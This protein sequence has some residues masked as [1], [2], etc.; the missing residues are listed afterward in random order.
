[1]SISAEDTPKIPSDNLFPVVGVGASAGGLEAFKQ[2]LQAIPHNS[3]LAYILVQ[4]LDPSH[5]SIL[6]EILQRVSKIPVHEIADNMKV[7]ADHIYIIPSNKILV[8]TDGVLKLDERLPKPHKNMPI[9][10]FFSSLAEVHREHA[11]GV[12]L[13]GTGTDGTMGLKAIKDQGGLTFAQSPE[14]AAYDGMPLSA[15]SSN[16]VD[17]ILPPADIPAKLLEL[18]QTINYSLLN[19]LEAEAK[20]KENT[21]KQILALLQLRTKVDFT[22]YKQTT[23]RRRILRR[24]VIHKLENLADYLKLARDNKKEQ[25]NL[26]QDLLIPVT[27]FFRDIQTFESVFHTILP[28]IVKDKSLVVPIRIWVAGC[29]TGQEAYS[30]A[31]CLSEFLGD[32]SKGVK[33][34]LFATDISEKAI[35]KARSGSYMNSEV[36]G[37]SEKRLQTFFDKINGCY[38]IKKSI[39]DMCVF[40]P[41]NFLKDAPFAR[42]DLISCRNVLIYMEPYLQKKALSTFHYALNNKGFL[43]LGKSETTGSL[44]E[45]FSSANKFEKLYIRKDALPRF[46]SFTSERTEGVFKQLDSRSGT[47]MAKKEDFHKNADDILLSKYCPA[48]V[49]VNEVFE[50]VQYRGSTGKYLEPL[51]GKPTL[52]VIEMARTGLSFE[53]RNLLHKSKTSSEPVCKGAIPVDD[54]KRLVTIEVI[55]LLN[56][57]EP[58]FLIVFKDT[59]G[60]IKQVSNI[61]NEQTG[62]VKLSADQLHLQQLGKELSQAREDM[63]SI[64]EDQEAANEEL[65]SANEELLS[66]NEELQSLNEELE[67]TKEEM[68][69]TVEELIIVNQELYQSN[70]QLND[71]RKY[72]EAI[73]TTIREPLLVLDKD[74]RVKSANKIFYKNFG[75]AELDTEGKLLYELGNEQWN[76]PS[77][78]T[79]LENILHDQ[80]FEDFEVTQAF[81]GLGERIMLLNAS[82][83]INE[84]SNEQLILL[85]IED[86]TE[87]RK[88]E[89]A[90]KEF[91]E[92]LER[93]V[94]ERTKSLKVSNTLL[95]Q[96]NK[97]L[98]QFAFIASHDLQEPLR[99]IQI[100]SSILADRYADQLPDGARELIEKMKVSTERMSLLIRDVLNYSIVSQ[101]EIQFEK[102]DLNEI[103]DK[104]LIDFDL[105][106]QQKNAIIIRDQLPRI[107]AIP[108]QINQL[109]YNL[110]GN[111][112]KFSRSETRPV[113]NISFK[114]LLPAEVKKHEKLNPELL[115]C[116]LVF[117]DN[118][119]GFDQQFARQIFLIFKKLNISN[120]YIGTGIGLALC[121]SIVENHEGEI[122]AE[123]KKNEGAAFYILLPIR[124]VSRNLAR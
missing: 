75:V 122:Y 8:A 87:T 71:A 60:T 115:Y 109:F 99:K 31:M 93:Q 27:S 77:L 106:I 102:T 4:H 52:K 21:F 7:A 61:E 37:V 24:M 42:V 82:Q 35:Q 119:I 79:R 10:I 43:F 66:G 22:Y 112:L 16:M 32:Q 23:I 86:I 100:F 54:G 36:N 114:M 83:L 28:A 84:N 5:E 29:S 68:Q 59:P 34:Q 18:S 49:V 9:D 104:V 111:S 38:Q 72:A 120:Q 89:L 6:T 20:E 53:L 70:E 110:I 39:R 17:I 73:V 117:K 80:R 96:S 62:E 90:L 74:L 48:G 45:L 47:R 107:D 51:P 50:I 19:P 67:T 94:A 14:S 98:E 97:N 124:Q 105:P 113:I 13:S 33:I 3:G 92:K 88:I 30:I 1:M 121:C 85:A 108:L 26:Y 2:L 116:Q 65:Q 46:Q 78:R 64:T 101:S 123:A 44:S 91:N 103:L 76:I 25:D 118:G 57:I 63:H 15:I 81:Q 55:P 40:A 11:I 69:S 12:V 41:H 58:H 95:E 56:T